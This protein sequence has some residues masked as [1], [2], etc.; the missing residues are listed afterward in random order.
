[1]I[2]EP[3]REKTCRQGKS[4]VRLKPTYSDTETRL[5]I[6]ILHEANLDILLSTKQLTKALI[7]LRG[8]TGWSVPLLFACDMPGFP[9]LRL[10]IILYMLLKILTS[11]SLNIH[12]T[13]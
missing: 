11:T 13:Q 3:C 2:M 4:H 1:M 12:T 8:C 10:I 6:K 7:R 9:A 5:K